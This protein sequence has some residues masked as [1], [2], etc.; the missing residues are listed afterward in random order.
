VSDLMTW[1]TNDSA[2]LRAALCRV[3]LWWLRGQDLN[4]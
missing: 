1:A 4:L 2:A 3:L